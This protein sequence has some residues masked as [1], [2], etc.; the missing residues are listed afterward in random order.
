MKDRDVKE[1]KFSSTNDPE[2]GKRDFRISTL[3]VFWGA[4]LASMGIGLA[5]AN[6]LKGLNWSAKF[7][8]F[9]CLGGLVFVRF[10]TKNKLRSVLR[11]VCFS[12]G[13]F[14]YCYFLRLVLIFLQQ[15]DEAEGL[16]LAIPFV[17]TCGS[18]IPLGA[19]IWLQAI[20]IIWEQNNRDEQNKSKSKGRSSLIERRQLKN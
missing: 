19:G 14:T 5:T 3:V 11:I 6:S 9:A 1:F 17:F 2:L 8:F 10:R 13:A 4:Y 15:R 16:A 12:T 7:L 18:M 20:I